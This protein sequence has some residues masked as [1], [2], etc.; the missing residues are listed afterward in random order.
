MNHWKHTLLASGLTLALTNSASATILAYD[1]FATDAT[2]SGQNYEDG[3]ALGSYLAGAGQD[4]NGVDKTRLGFNGGWGQVDSQMADNVNSRAITGGLSYPGFA[5]GD[6]GTGNPYR[7]NAASSGSKWIGRDLTVSAAE[8]SGGYYVAALVDFNGADGGGFGWAIPGRDNYVEYNGTNATFT[9]AGTT[10][11][12][13]T[14]TP[15]SGTNLIVIQYTTETGGSN[16][17]FY[18]R[19]NLWVNPDLSGGDLGSVTSTG[20]GIGLLSSGSVQDLD[21]A[22]LSSTGLDQDEIFVDE[23]YFTTTPDDFITVPEPSA[24]AL[25]AGL[26]VLGLLALRRR[27]A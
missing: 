19:W 13:A 23:L 8:I 7:T 1:G 2:G 17:S 11:D 10:G 22:F 12:T 21:Y 3:V 25:M 4:F 14:F 20:F 16:T 24:Y 26:G 15:Q 18:T 5:T 6:T 27:R 9:S